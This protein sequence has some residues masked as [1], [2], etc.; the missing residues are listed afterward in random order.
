MRRGHHHSLGAKGSGPHLKALLPLLLSGQ[1]VLADLVLGA[2]RLEN[3]VNL[4]GV[5]LILGV[6]LLVGGLCLLR[7]KAGAALLLACGQEERL[8]GGD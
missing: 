1:G 4:V 8:K 2:L 5:N 7:G 3:G 6:R